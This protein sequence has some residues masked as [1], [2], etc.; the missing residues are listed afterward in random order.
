MDTE[1]KQGRPQT[2]TDETAQ[3]L[4]DLWKVSESI[5]DQNVCDLIGIT[6]GQLQGWLDRETPA[7]VIIGSEQ[8]RAGLRE[9]RTRA[10]AG[11]KISYLKKLHNLIEAAEEKGDFGTAARSL[12]W[13]LEKQ[14]PQEYA[15]KQHIDMTQ[16]REITQ[17]SKKAMK[18]AHE[19]IKKL[20]KE[21]G[22]NAD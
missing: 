19:Y 7:T 14:F 5:S 10:K 18:E 2:L 22:G 17:F 4:A 20:E 6:S 15:N 16:N 12:C 13:L 1:K 11:I 3:K 21:Y 8:I 9:I